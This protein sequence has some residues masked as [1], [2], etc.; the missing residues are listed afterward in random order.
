VVVD[1]VWA[2]VVSG[3]VELAAE[4][5]DSLLE[6]RGGCMRAGLGT[7]RSR[8]EGEL[9][10]VAIAGHELGDPVFGDPGGGGHVSIGAAFAKDC[11]NDVALPAH[12]ALHVN[13]VGTMS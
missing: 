5:E 8:L 12:G 11:L 1:G 4:G 3:C 2:G 9:T 6:L 7:A 10:T 13:V